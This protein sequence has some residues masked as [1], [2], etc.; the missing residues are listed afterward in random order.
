MFSLLLLGTSK[1]SARFL[2]RRSNQYFSSLMNLPIRTFAAASN[3][4][5]EDTMPENVRDDRTL[6]IAQNIPNI[7]NDFILNDLLHRDHNLSTLDALYNSNQ[8]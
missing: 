6:T 3:Y 1:T 2:T 8:K 7:K 4:D 5:D